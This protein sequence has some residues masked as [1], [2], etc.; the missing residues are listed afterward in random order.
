MNVDSEQATVG[1][2]QDMALAAPDLL[3]C[4]VASGAPF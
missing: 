3:A 2:G 4:V 1:V